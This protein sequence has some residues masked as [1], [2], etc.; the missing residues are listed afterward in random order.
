MSTYMNHIFILFF[1]TFV[2]QCREYLCTIN[3]IFHLS[4]QVSLEDLF[5]EIFMA[6]IR[7]MIKAVTDRNNFWLEIAP[8]I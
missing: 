8:E 5:L 7:N 6:R 3:E 1:S 2:I 4:I